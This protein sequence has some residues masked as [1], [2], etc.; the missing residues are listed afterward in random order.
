MFALFFDW[1]IRIGKSFTVSTKICEK[2]GKRL[3]S[4]WSHD[5]LQSVKNMK[6]LCT[7]HKASSI[8]DLIS[9]EKET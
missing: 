6:L 4:E 8:Y 9:D 2:K 7:G 3:L 1:I 5:V